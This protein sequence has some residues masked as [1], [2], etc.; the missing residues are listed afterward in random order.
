MRKANRGY[1]AT[2]GKEVAL[3]RRDVPA[4]EMAAGKRAAANGAALH[5]KKS[6]WRNQFKSFV[7]AARTSG[8]GSLESIL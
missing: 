7:N 1:A 2:L 3:A 8:G 6:G 4:P 5:A